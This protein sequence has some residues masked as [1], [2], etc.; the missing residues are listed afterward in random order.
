L[1]A[2]AA[3]ARYYDLLYQDKNYEAESQYIAALLSEYAPDARTILDIGCGTGAHARD[4][5]RKGFT[6][7]GVD[8]SEGM[9]AR[10]NETKA[11][12]NADLSGKL[13][14]SHADAR[15]VELGKTFDAVVSLFHVMSYQTSNDDLASAFASAR[16]HLAHGGVFIFDC[17]YGPAVLTDRPKV[18]TKTF[19]DDGLKLERLSEPT[20]DA[21]RNTVEV[22]YTLHVTGEARDNE[23]IRESH[24]MRYLF[25]PEVEM[26]LAANDLKLES[27]REWMTARAPGFNSW[28]VCYVARA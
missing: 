7:H 23:T 21:E 19:A 27:S 25:T 18:V 12:L 3:Y 16:R 26:M 14:F 6:V 13:A 8:I 10:A 28:N 9:L 15:S 20:M 22:K 1:S 17:W 5:A 2:F 4:L 24:L 11:T